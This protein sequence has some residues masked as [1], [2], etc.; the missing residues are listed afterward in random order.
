MKHKFLSPNLVAF[1]FATTFILSGCIRFPT[2]HEFGSYSNAEKFYAEGKYDKAIG[3]YK[4]YIDEQPEGNLA[5]ISKYY[6]G[7][8]YAA[9]KKNSEAKSE[10][11]A[12]INKYPDLI[13]AELSK[14]QLK[15]L[16]SE[17]PKSWLNRDRSG[18]LRS[19]FCLG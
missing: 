7:K 4:K 18:L 15:N 13:W 8:S 17:P 14:E 10:F 12:I 3:S 6:I 19:P 2:H 1:F 9:L 16:A 5:I 11:E